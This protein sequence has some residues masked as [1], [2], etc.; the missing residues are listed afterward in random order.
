MTA[1]EDEA[2]SVVGQ[3][4][5]DRNLTRTSGGVVMEQVVVEE[6]SRCSFPL[7]Q[8]QKDQSPQASNYW[9]KDDRTGPWMLLAAQVETN[10][11]QSQAGSEEPE[12]RKV[13]VSNLLQEAKVI[14]TSVSLR[15]SVPEQD[16]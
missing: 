8:A 10:E 15:R 14:E 4:E 2:I 6:P 11:E 12:P 7:I 13:Q 3:A 1:C 5:V 16:A 9:A